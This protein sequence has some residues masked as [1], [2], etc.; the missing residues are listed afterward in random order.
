MSNSTLNKMELKT[1]LTFEELLSKKTFGAFDEFVSVKEGKEMGIIPVSYHDI[2]SDKCECGS[3]MIIKKSLTRIQ[4]CNPRCYIKLGYMLDE[5]FTRFGC[6]D[7]GPATC[8]STM[9]ALVDKLEIPSH[10]EVLGLPTEKLPYA[11][12]HYK[13][14]EFLYAKEQIFS[15]SYDLSELVPKLALPTLDKTASKIFSEY[16]DVVDFIEE[17]KEYEDFNI[18]MLEHGIK[19]PWKIYCM[20]TYII[21]I[22]KAQ[23]LF[24][25]NLQERPLQEID[26][27]ITGHV[28]PEGN[29]MTRDEFL[30]Y[31]NAL[32]VD[33]QGVRRFGFKQTGALESVQHIVADHPSSSRKYKRGQARGV[34]I[35]ST[36]LV[37]RLKDLMKEFNKVE[38]KNF[39]E[40]KDLSEFKNLN[41]IGKE[42]ENKEHKEIDVENLNDLFS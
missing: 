8:I 20:H 4:C 10:I 36:D 29:P 7:L 19:D 41:E 31:L 14:G 35:T 27:V 11:I 6:K 23:M 34:L 15:K 18:Y 22:L 16:D 26:I 28:A 37:L 33:T 42:Q 39:E 25:D 9:R 17:F 12:T 3:E 2:F 1:G 21:D 5:L 24:I 30:G 40:T 38:T 32:G 13:Y